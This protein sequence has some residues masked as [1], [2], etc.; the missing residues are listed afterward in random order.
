[1]VSN[2]ENITTAERKMAQ[3]SIELLAKHAD[4]WNGNGADS[5]EISLGDS[6][7]KMQIPLKAFDFLKAVLGNMAAGDTATLMP[8][9]PELNVKQTADFLYFP[10]ERVEELL[11]DKEIPH[12]QL[13]TEKLMRLSDILMYQEDFRKKRQEALKEI[14]VMSEEMGL[15][16]V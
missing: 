16:E 13:G 14:I 15:Y 7:K 3:S 6:G 5:I 12:R 1:M 9:T 4:E 8:G 2:I 11:K 10:I